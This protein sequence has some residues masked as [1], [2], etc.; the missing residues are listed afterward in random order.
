MVERAQ[1]T[2]SKRK[3]IPVLL[4][5]EAKN[6]EEAEKVASRYMHCPYVA[7]IAQ[8]GNMVYFMYALPEEQ[9]WWMDEIVKDPSHLRLEK[10]NAV[11]PEKLFYPREVKPHIPREKTTVF[12]CGPASSISDCTECPAYQRCLGCPGTVHY[13]E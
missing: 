7:F 4:T 9:H 13:K 5:G 1:N 3:F 11:Y 2:Q 8:D 6:D 12:T 10:V